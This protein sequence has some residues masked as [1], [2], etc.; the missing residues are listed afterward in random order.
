MKK[1]LVPI[2]FSDVSENAVTFAIDLAK[3]MQGELTLY[4]SIHFNY[5]YDF[6]YG[7]YGAIA[8]IAEE[9][10]EDA[11]KRVKSFIDKLKTELNISYIINSDSL[12]TAVKKLVTNEGFDLVVVGTTRALFH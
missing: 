12:V 11:E 7:D 5:F 8:S 9:V 1:I 3:K 6:Q 4:H 2:D 10:N